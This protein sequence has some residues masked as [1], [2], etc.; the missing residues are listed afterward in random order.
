M[1]VWL[2]NL[3][4]KD[5]WLKLFSLVLA[6]L[7][8]FVVNGMDVQ[9]EAL[10][11]RPR[12]LRALDRRTFRNLPIIVMSSAEDARVVHVNP[13]EVEVTVAGEAKVLNRLL[14]RDIRVIVDLTGIEAAH[15]LRKR[16]EVSTPAGVTRV[17]VDPDEV[18]V[19]FPA[20][21]STQ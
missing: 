14:D 9:K 6:V 4:L 21:R 12:P 13:K 16:V 2:Q 11:G 3:V 18:Q 5:V 20:N 17:N 10:S 19:V 7:V 8:W 1:I 15:D